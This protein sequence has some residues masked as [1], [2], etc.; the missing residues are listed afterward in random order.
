MASSNLQD[1]L[2]EVVRGE[3]LI[4]EQTLEHYSRDASLFKVR[5]KV[6]VKPRNVKDV[7]QIIRFVA[8]NQKDFPGLAITG[9]AA[10]TC[11]SG[12][13]IGEG[14]ILD[15]TAYFNRESLDL[16]HLRATVEPGVFYRDFEKVTLPEHV[17]MPVYPA[18]KG[19]AAFGGMI[20][21]NC[22]SENSLRYGQMRNFVTRL[23]MVLAN[24]QEY[25]FRKLTMDELEQKMKQS[26][27]EGE[28]Y[29]KTFELVS[30]HYDVIKAAKP[31]V[32]KNSSGYALWDV[33]DKEAG[34]FDLTQLFTGSQGTLGLLTE[35]EVRLVETK[36]HQRVVTLF[37]NSWDALPEA[38]NELLP[39]G[40]QTIETFDDTTLKLGI[41]FMPE[42]AKKAGTNLFSFLLQFLPEA[43]I[44]LKLGGLPKL[45]AIVEI[46]ED[47]SREAD[48]K[49][50]QVVDALKDNALHYRVITDMKQ[51]EK[52]W[53][54][55]RES[56]NLLRQK[57]K[58]K[59][60]APFIE[61][62]C[63]RPE[64]LPEF[65]KKLM[66]V[67][68]EYDIKANLAGHAGEGNFHII[69]LMDLKKESERA[70]I[71]PV[72]NIIYD[73]IIAYKGT[74]TAEHNDGI[75]RTPYVQK[76]FGDEIYALFEKTK[77][78]FDPHNIFNPGKKVGGTIKFL[79]E[80]IVGK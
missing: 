14:I 73:L 8:A 34:T 16:P 35:A 54:M 56:F 24:G 6:V 50:K 31:N 53:I 40:V 76:M 52:F 66:V 43:I 60:T 77:A 37:F 75:M 22:G 71:V 39:I 17:S 59:Q 48:K 25:S 5:P 74:I 45:I 1:R 49:V 3:V 36:E 58:N 38:V 78:I 68:K 67:L 27:F 30:S 62:F 61:D 46:A 69:P 13:A 11:M 10:G 41:K 51:A 12:G 28:I 42:I 44:S 20:M 23:K 57:V 21:N 55:R 32:V 63:V 70:K 80:H 26:D 19:L 18:S 7:E 79:E 33:Y 64:V 4:D 65:L 9:R 15:F 29:R 47:S 72:A 2:R